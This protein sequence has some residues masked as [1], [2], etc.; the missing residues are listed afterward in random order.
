VDLGVPPGCTS[1]GANALNNLGHVVGEAT[2]TNG[3]SVAFLWRN[4]SMVDLNTLLPEDSGWYL[5]TALYINDLDQIVGYGM[6]D[7]E[8]AWYL[9]S[10]GSVN[11]PPVAN[12]G[13]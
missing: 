12:A 1:S 7:G 4:S 11:H 8:F 10:V 2:K 6:F 13:A 9:F 5:S 3:T